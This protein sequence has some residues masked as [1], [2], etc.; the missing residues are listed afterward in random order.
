M[1]AV[2]TEAAHI[3]DLSPTLLTFLEIV[4]DRQMEGQSRL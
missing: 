4:P 3:T 2:R 1:K